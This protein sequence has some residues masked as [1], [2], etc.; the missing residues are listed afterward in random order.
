MRVVLL[1]FSSWKNSMSIYVPSWVK[2]N[3]QRFPGVARS[4]GSG[5]EILSAL[6]Q[7]NL[8]SDSKAFVALMN[9]LRDHRKV[10]SLP[11]NT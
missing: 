1:W 10:I 8:E 4:N 7:N 11:A 3:R 9:H 6:G 5:M 2:R